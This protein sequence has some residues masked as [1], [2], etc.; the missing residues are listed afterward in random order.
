MRF[1]GAILRNQL[2][3]ILLNTLAWT[4]FFASILVNIKK[5]KKVLTLH[6]PYGVYIPSVR[7]QLKNSARQKM[8]DFMGQM[9]KTLRVW[10]GL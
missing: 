6:C 1:G 4:Q 5:K 10:R 2:T 3:H 9:T 7:M 8:M